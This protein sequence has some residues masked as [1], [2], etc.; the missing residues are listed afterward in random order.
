[1]AK[2]DWIAGAIKH[3][4]AFTKKAQGAHESVSQYAHHVLAPDSKA[5][6][7]TKRQ[8]RLALTLKKMHK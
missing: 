4:G 1:M 5:S 8:A 2:K 3:P 7:T 6:E